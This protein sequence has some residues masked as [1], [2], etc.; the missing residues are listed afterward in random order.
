MGHFTS[1]LVFGYKN[2]LYTIKRS[3]GFLQWICLILEAHHSE[4]PLKA[5]LHEWNLLPLNRLKLPIEAQA[6]WWKLGGRDKDQKLLARFFFVVT[7]VTSR[8][9]K[10]ECALETSNM[11]TKSINSHCYFQPGN[12]QAITAII[13]WHV[14]LRGS[15]CFT[16]WMTSSQEASFLWDRKYKSIITPAFLTSS[17]VSPQLGFVFTAF[18]VTRR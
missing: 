9:T 17:R 11:N 16:A 18:C 3:R 14:G 5:T 12:K 2:I 13:S 10:N 15:S 8:G 7:M 4:Q 1:S 6:A